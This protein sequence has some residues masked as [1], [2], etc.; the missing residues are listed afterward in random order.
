MDGCTMGTDSH[1]ASALIGKILRQISKSIHFKEFIEK[2][3][4]DAKTI[5]EDLMESLFHHLKRIKNELQLEREELLSTL[6]LGVVNL[7]NKEAEIITVGDGLI[8]CNGKLM[9]YEQNDKPD[10]LGYHLGK[11]FENWFGKQKQRLSLNNIND[12][13]ISTDGI[14]TFKKFN[15]EKYVERSDE[16]VFNFL[17]KNKE[18]FEND[19]MLKKK[20][21]EIEK[22]WGLKPTDDLAIIRLIIEY[23][24][25]VP[26][27]H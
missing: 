17:L 9:E 7:K 24:R 6:I 14:F 10:Y 23:K 4:K 18:G 26:P 21:L 13:S 16:D 15:N 1:F 2:K 19:N 5:L 22:V 11:D 27:S 20:L 12:L 3:E 25:H 8:C